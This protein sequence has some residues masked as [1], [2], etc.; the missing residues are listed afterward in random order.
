MDVRRRR[1]TGL[2]VSEVPLRPAE[3]LATGRLALVEE[4]GNL[5]TIVIKDPSSSSLNQV[6]TWFSKVERD[7]IAGRERFLF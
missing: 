6:E 5:C 7:V 3:Q 2:P 1:E 4:G